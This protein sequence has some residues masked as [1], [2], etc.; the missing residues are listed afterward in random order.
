MQL[1]SRGDDGRRTQESHGGEMT[2]LRTFT[3]PATVTGTEA[4]I[5]LG[6]QMIDAW[7]ADGIFQVATDTIQQTKTER[8]FAASKRFFRMPFASKASCI[9]DLTYAGYV[10]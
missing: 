9:S 10:A 8:A 6:R 1:R 2:E 5:E 7:R 3:L 4:Q